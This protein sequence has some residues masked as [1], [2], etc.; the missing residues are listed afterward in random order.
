MLI[1]T[2]IVP[3]LR[4]CFL[5]LKSFYLLIFVS[6]IYYPWS[7]M[8]NQVTCLMILMAWKISWCVI[9]VCRKCYLFLLKQNY[10]HLY[11]HDHKQQLY[12]KDFWIQYSITKKLHRHSPSNSLWGKQ[13]CWTLSSHMSLNNSEI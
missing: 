3:L 10:F 2:S 12:A 1:Y 11:N 9:Y 6:N 4:C 5:F 7:G 8:I 13:M